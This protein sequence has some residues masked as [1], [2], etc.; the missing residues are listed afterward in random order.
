[1]SR[2]IIGS[3]IL[4]LTETSSTNEYAVQL[5]RNKRPAEGIVI[6]SENQTHGRGMDT[7]TWES[8]EG[9]NLTFSFI[10]YPRFLAVEKQFIL[11]QAIALALIKFVSQKVPSHRVTVKWPNDIYINEKKVCGI[12]I[13]NSILGHSIDSVIAGIGLNVNQNLFK[14]AAPNP[15]SLSM[16]SGINYSLDELLEELC[17]LLDQRYH[18][19]MSG[20]TDKLNEEYLQNLFRIN[21][22]HK[23]AIRGIECDAK[24]TGISSYGQLMLVDN[25]SNEFVCD[26]KE[27][28]YYT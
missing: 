28:K 12:L 5:I 19:L 26:V 13:Q 23:F 21:E 14:S 22:W 17:Q 15:I 18:Q 20:E 1:M 25:K 9:K 8:E 16:I 3:Q 10:I 4:R 11:N 24:I 7:N 27:V 2:Q 6:R